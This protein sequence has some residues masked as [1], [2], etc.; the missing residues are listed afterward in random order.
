[1]AALS[2]FNI[3][4]SKRLHQFNKR[5]IHMLSAAFLI[6]IIL[7]SEKCKK[8][9]AKMAIS[10]LKRTCTVMHQALQLSHLFL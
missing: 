6:V 4:L 1:M 3:F 2:C 5:C 8:T 7:A 10:Q 9:K